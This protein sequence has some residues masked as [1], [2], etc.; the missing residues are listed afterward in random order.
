MRFPKRT[1]GRP[2]LGKGQPADNRQELSQ[3]LRLVQVAPQE[4][5]GRATWQRRGQV[6]FR[7]MLI[8]VVHGELPPE[9]KR[10][11]LTTEEG[12]ADDSK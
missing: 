2:F 11:H 6:Q 7:N 3:R 8:Q 10:H 4:N 5:A 12:I 1:S 9:A